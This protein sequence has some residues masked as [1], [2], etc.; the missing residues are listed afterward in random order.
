MGLITNAPIALDE[1]IRVLPLLKEKLDSKTLTLSEETL[2]FVN[3]VASSLSEDTPSSFVL[4]FGS[5]SAIRQ[6]VI[7]PA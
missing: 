4:Q 5:K 1:K 3:Q 7:L 6:A 2:K